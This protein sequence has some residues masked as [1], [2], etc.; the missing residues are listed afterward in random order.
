[1]NLEFQLKEAWPKL[2][3]VAVLEPEQR[4]FVVQHGPLVEVHRDWA[5]EGV[6]DG[7]FAAGDLDQ[8]DSI[9]GTGIRKRGNDIVF[10]GSS[11][12]IDRLWYVQKAGKIFVSNSLP[13]LLELSGLALRHDYAFYT[14]DLVTVQKIGV[15][16][17]INTIPTDGEPL[18]IVYFKNLLYRE[19]RI[20]KIE[21][22][23]L[24]PHFSDFGVYE[25]YLKT[26]ARKLGANARDPGRSFPVERLVGL[27]SGYDSIATAVIS[28]YAGCTRAASITNPSSFWRGSDSGKHIADYLGMN[29]QLHR[30][31]KKNYRNEIALWAGAGIP[32]SRNFSLFDYPKPLCLFFSG[33]Y[34]DVMWDLKIKRK[35]EPRGG[36]NE[37]LCE[38]RLIEGVFVSVVPWWGIRRSEDVRKIN[39]SKEMAPWMIGNDYD[40]PVARRIIEEAGIP[41]GEF[42]TRKKNTSSTRPLRWPSGAEARNSFGRHLRQNGMSVPGPLKI[43]MYALLS[44]LS[45][46]TYQ[47]IG[48]PLKVKQWWKP[49]LSFP[50]RTQLFVWA[51]HELRD[52]YYRD[53]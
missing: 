29:C 38:F 27:S 15:F 49:W 44:I 36:I 26:L 53:K 9:F 30:H 40:R 32:G 19:G 31:A 35:I 18:Q 5:V 48:K 37:L 8:T 6:W 10:V 17:H 25:D 46:L 12:G 21:K 16:N 33:G 24:A 4:R 2:A 41:R 28:R 22:P 52:R 3:W 42:A 7:D 50:G 39:S 1:M 43:K 23:E 47:N 51:N 34:G 14:E 20:E 45:N 11:T 13:G